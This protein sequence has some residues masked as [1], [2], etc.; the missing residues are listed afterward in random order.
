MIDSE[1]DESVTKRGAAKAYRD[2]VFELQAQLKELMEENY[3]L[4]L[5]KD[6]MTTAKNACETVVNLQSQL[7]DS[8]SDWIKMRE[9]A[10]ETSRQLIAAEKKLGI[11]IAALKQFKGNDLPEWV[12]IE[13]NKA[14]KQIDQ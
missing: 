14:L 2:K 9:I 11:A 13:T 3:Q 8:E 6:F 7:S 1:L 10:E 12:N 4:K 5:N